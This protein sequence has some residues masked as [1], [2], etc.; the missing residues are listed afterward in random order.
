[1]LAISCHA[2]QPAGF[3]FSQ[4]PSHTIFRVTSREI[5][6]CTAVMAKTTTTKPSRPSAIQTQQNQP[7]K[8]H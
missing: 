8:G 4:I 3:L 5:S 6:G 7:T 2:S 1:M